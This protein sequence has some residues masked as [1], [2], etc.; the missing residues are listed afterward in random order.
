M[1]FEWDPDKARANE[2]KH[3][4]SFFEACEVFADDHSSTTRD[5][6]HSQDENRYLIFGMSRDGKHLVVSYTERRN[7]SGSVI[8]RGQSKNYYQFRFLELG[9]TCIGVFTL[10]PNY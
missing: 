8:V 6:D 9:N 1:E 5:P 2:S 7:S 4:I 10:T 3:G